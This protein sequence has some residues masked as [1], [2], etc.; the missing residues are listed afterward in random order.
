MHAQHRLFSQIIMSQATQFVIPVF[1][2]EYRWTEENCVQLWR[3]ILEV[4]ADPKRAEHFVGSVVYIGT[5][6]NA[7]GFTRWLLIDGQQRVTTLTL[8]SAALRDH[9]RE[10]KWVGPEDGPTATRIDAYYLRNREE[11]GPRELKLQLRSHD[12]ATLRAIITRTDLP[13]T[14]SVNVLEN[15]ELFRALLRDADPEVV[16]RG[17]NRLVLVDVTL[18]RGRDDPQ[19]IFESLNSTGVDLSTLDLIRNFIL[20]SLDE[21]DQT[22]LH[23][24]YWSKIDD[25]FRDNDRVFENFV[26]DY[27]ALRTRPTKLERADRV[28]GAFRKEFSDVGHDPEQLEPILKDLLRRARQYAAFAVG[29]GSDPRSR[30]FASLRYLGDVP[31]ILIMRLLEVH[32]V[33]KTLSELDLLEAVRLIESYM[34]RRA[35]LGAQNKGYSLEFAKVAY[36]IDDAQPLASLRA[37]LA[38]MPAAYAFPEDQEFIRALLEGDLYHKRVCFHLLDGLENRDRN[39]QSDTSAYSIEHVIPQNERLSEEWRT[40][41]GPDWKRVQQTWLHRLGNLTLTGYNSTYSDKFLEEKQTIPNGFRQSPIRISE[42]LRTTPVWGPAEMQ[43]RGEKLAGRAVAIW[44][45]LKADTQMIRAMAQEEL[46]AKAAQ[47]RVDSVTMGADALKIFSALSDRIRTAFPEVI[48]MPETKSVSYHDP[49]FFVELIPRAHGLG[50]LIGIDYN[51]VEE[52]DELVQDATT[53]KFVGN[54][55]YPGGV[56]MI[57]RTLEQADQAMRVITQARSLISGT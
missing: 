16:Y 5:A 53:Y 2:R 3:D 36:R 38:R 42:D 57:L 49:E 28:Y 55:N 44:P 47:R 10:T 33:H 31:A 50:V 43:A 8:L 34:L 7:A 11:E 51:E 26:R 18:E 22:R 46:R 17:I 21:R 27:L 14:I 30:A 9:I 54:A 40:M 52:P 19:L 48:E 15:Y 1:Q 37:A 24:Q 41:L 23:R 4:G 35:V 56:L 45:A 12:D 32:E 39:E 29:S 13:E 6:D 25:L 20:M